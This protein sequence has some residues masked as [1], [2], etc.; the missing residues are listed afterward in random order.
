[1]VSP[2]ALANKEREVQA[3][4]LS[5]FWRASVVALATILSFSAITLFAVDQ[6]YRP[7]AFVIDQ[8]KIKGKFRYLTPSDVEA[9]I[10]TDA[11]TNFFSIDLLDIKRK[12]EDL[13]W[14][15][16]ADVRR[17]W[18]NALSIKVDEHIPVMRWQESQW[19]TS[20]GKVIT[21]PNEI[22]LPKVITLQADE[23]D[24]LLAL[25][26]AF[27]WK[28]RLS[29]YGLELQKLKL[30]TSQA[31][32]LTLFDARHDAQFALLL[33]RDQVEQRLMRFQQLFK[34][35]FSQSNMKIE[36]VD[37][38]YPDGLAIKANQVNSE[39][40]ASHDRLALLTLDYDASLTMASVIGEQR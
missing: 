1:M 5:R 31:W 29:K 20:T 2:R 9:A 13:Q 22:N 11:L 32:T 23:S 16:H 39:P 4:R 26:T 36:R 14:V 24:S 34:Q 30:S 25:S 3:K 15:A 18:P 27:R 10:G 19:V 6:L 35:Q 17:E 21:L 37:A 7:D 8:L 38:R 12:V 33:G 28:K 40:L